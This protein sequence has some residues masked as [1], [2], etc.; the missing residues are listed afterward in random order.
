MI[1]FIE[2]TGQNILIYGRDNSNNLMKKQ[3]FYYNKRDAKKDFKNHFGLKG[4][5]GIQFVEA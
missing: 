2:K 5:K 1:I 3:Y 4:I